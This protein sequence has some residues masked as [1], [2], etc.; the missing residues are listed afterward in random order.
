MALRLSTRFLV[1]LGLA[2]FFGAAGL[3][4][5]QQAGQTPAG[6]A[7]TPDPRTA[8]V[9]GQV[10]DADTGQP[11]SGAVVRLILRTAAGAPPAAPA[12]PLAT[13]ARGGP[14]PPPQFVEITDS[15][16]RFLFHDLPKGA[17]ALSATAP[18]FMAPVGPAGNNMGPVARPIPLGEG[19]HVF[20]QKIRL[21]RFAAISGTIIDESGEPAVGFPVQA[22]KRKAPGAVTS[23][24]MDDGFFGV[25]DDRGAYR[26][27]KIPPGEYF[28]VSPQTQMTM[29]AQSGDDLLSGLMGGSL[30]GVMGD[31]M[32]SGGPG[33]MG[34]LGGVRVGNLMWS[35]GTSSGVGLGAAMGGVPGS[36]LPGPPPPA[37]GRLYAYQTT[38]YPA[39]L[40]PGQATSITLRSGDNREGIDFQLRPVATS[41]VSGTVMGPTGP[42]KNIA[43]RLVPA[44]SDAGGDAAFDV[45]TAVTAN[46]GS[47]TMLGVPNGEY[48]A[49]VEK[50]A[51]QDFREMMADSPE[52]AAMMPAGLEAFMPKGSKESLSAETPVGVGDTDTT[53]IALV[54]VAGAHMLGRVEFE[55]N[56]AKPAAQSMQSMTISATPVGRP[57]SFTTDKVGAN[58]EF[59]TSGFPPGRYILNVS[60]GRADMTPSSVMNNWMIKSITIG[61]RDVTN[62]GVELKNTD[63]ADIVLTFTDQISSLSGT[64]K[65]EPGGGFESVSVV[66]VPAEYQKWFASGGMQRR[67]PISTTDAKGAFNIG[68]LPPGDYL[69][70]AVDNGVLQST[71][72]VE[73]YDRLARIAKRVTVGA[74]EK[75]TVTLDITKVIK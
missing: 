9:M 74:G 20:D 8:L 37:S 34:A 42:M 19:E 40:T 35:S 60:P 17:A 10:I 4:A 53:G 15:E 13:G 21:V 30:G 46:D 51:T 16:G 54:M 73:F 55:G 61:G 63:V 28:V 41:R 3:S 49:K 1:I 24:T 62:E 68:R 36:H 59:K 32:A 72:N 6:A 18:G 5:R 48:I 23:S 56:S 64:V 52:I 33:I 22:V 12:M 38:Y 58:G 57:A 25:T 29:P 39:S 2:A 14:T 50:L 70:I 27:G 7:Q 26:I 11:I 71:E 75:K 67:N 45:A 66:L 65:G 44:G 31:L 69:I 47:F 43:V